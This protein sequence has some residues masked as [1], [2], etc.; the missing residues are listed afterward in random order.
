M[1]S[2]EEG[3]QLLHEGGDYAHPE[4]SSFG[5]S[6]EAEEATTMYLTVNVST[7][8]MNTD[9]LLETNTTGDSGPVNVPVY[10]TV[11]F[12]NQTQPIAVSLLKGTNVFKFSRST[13]AGIAIKEFLLYTNKPVVPPPNK[14]HTTKP[15]PPP[16]DYIEVPASTTCIKQGITEV[17]EPF[18]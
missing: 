6:I 10:F 14:N 1:W 5:Y 17:A 8:H 3:Q 16:E 12:W 4:T 11:G 2:F 13:P 15:V 18:C 7:W 9:L